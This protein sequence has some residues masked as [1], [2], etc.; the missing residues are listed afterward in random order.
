MKAKS[1]SLRTRIIFSL[2][3]IVIIGLA[4]YE[5]FNYLQI[6]QRLTQELESQADRKILRLKDNLIIPLW[7]LDEDWIAKM[8]SIE[9][10]DANTY[11][12]QVSGDENLFVSRIRDDHWQWVPGDRRA[13]TGDD[14]IERQQDIIHDE[15]KIGEVSLYLSKRSLKSE[16]NNE[17]QATVLRALT[18]MLLI[19]LF[20]GGTLNQLV[21]KP[22]FKILKIVKGITA[23]HYMDAPFD[24]PRS[25]ELGL[26]A[27]SIAT[28]QQNLRLREMERDRANTELH[29]ANQ[30]LASELQK[31]TKAQA[32]LKELNETLEQRIQA[33][34][35]ALQQSN[36]QLQEMSGVLENAKNGAE[37]AN[38]AKS[39]FLANMT[40]ELRT[41]M[42]AVLGFSRLMQN[43]NNLTIEQ[44]EVLDIINRS[45]N[46][47]LELI[48]QVLDMSKIESGRIVIENAPF[49][50]GGTIRD[51]IDMMHE[52]AESKGLTLE[53][54]QCS[55]FPR[56]V[57]ADAAK[58][59]HIMINLLSNAIKY[60]QQGA[61]VLRLNTQS[62]SPD[63]PLV[64]ICEVEDSGIGIAKEDLSRIFDAFVQV[65]SLSDQ[66]GT[67][68]GLVIT[69][70]Y[71]ELMGG[72]ITV[73]SEP[74]KGSI[75]RVYL[76]ATRV[77]ES[78]VE[79]FDERSVCSVI[80]LEP[81]QAQYRILVVEDQ[82]ESRL[83]LKRLLESVGFSVFEACNGLE[84]VEMF[85]R[86][87]PDF[88][89]MDRRMPVMDG[90][91]ATQ[92]ILA[93][94][95][96]QHTK[97]AAVTAS[98]YLEERQALLAAGVCAIVYKPY[99]NEEI[100]ECMATHLG[101][102]YQYQDHDTHTSSSHVL[103]YKQATQ[104]L[105]DCPETWLMLLQTAAG[106]LDVERCQEIIHQIEAKHVELAEHLLA[107]INQYDFEGLLKLLNHRAVS[108]DNPP[109]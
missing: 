101:I 5:L 57:S 55:S 17:A 97:I 13:V 42:N 19:V 45:G 8:I 25:D 77:N 95:E 70:Q 23:G 69:K 87:R 100:F 28:M 10:M 62:K 74:G 104:A 18:L 53:I 47:L 76:P 108:D 72:C 73:D 63:D 33:R 48:N 60:T 85:K 2:L 86:H 3:V 56:V 7:E 49:D 9:M 99:R 12:I 102:R 44:R 36:H 41:P 16:L 30:Q 37:A 81:G 54:D 96:G 80:G 50:L 88:I 65:G 94:P 27:Q 84:G 64:L 75:F 82:P 90:I 4:P 89:W 34:T 43:D 38:R 46:H 39:I 26:L 61:V 52:R 20:L 59:R 91:E 6:E 98:T 109:V 105:A 31:R 51:I 67:G 58:L 79:T 107:L 40:H 103:D 14:I 22:L 106:E 71:A 21:I 78:L 83:L 35:E 92:T 29:Q 32:S 93:L 68:L 15:A 24:T 1:S 11:A 66:H